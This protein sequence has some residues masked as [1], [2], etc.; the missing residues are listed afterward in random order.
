MA[1]GKALGAPSAG[2]FLC[3]P[4][5]RLG[6]ATRVGPA[7]HLSNVEILSIEAQQWE[8]THLLSVSF[9]QSGQIVSHMR[10]RGYE[11]PLFWCYNPFL[12]IPYLLIPASARV[13]H[14]TENY[15]DF[16]T[17]SEDG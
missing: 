11:R 14:G 4:E 9:R 10:A 1:L 15:F 7:A 13:F 5:L 2:G 8:L 17:L 16:G 12:V 3:L 6:E